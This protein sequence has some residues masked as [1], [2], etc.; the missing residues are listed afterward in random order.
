MAIKD[1]W[2]HISTFMSIFEKEKMEEIDDIKQSLNSLREL[3]NELKEEQ[4][5]T[6]SV[7]VY[8]TARYPPNGKPH[9][10]LD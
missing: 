5:K 2:D 4:P 3:L 1:F 6:D 9:D 8:E 10:T 7:Y